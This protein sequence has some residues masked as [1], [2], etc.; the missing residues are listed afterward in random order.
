MANEREEQEIAD[1]NKKYQSKHPT[2]L[3]PDTPSLD[4]S[5][6]R[7]EDRPSIEC[8]ATRRDETE[9]GRHQTLVACIHIEAERLQEPEYCPDKQTIGNAVPKPTTALLERIGPGEE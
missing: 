8:I 6:K 4:V 1:G 5:G 2:P 9:D 3:M 7:V